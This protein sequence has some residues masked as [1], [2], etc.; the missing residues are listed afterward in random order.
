MAETTID[1]VQVRMEARS[2]PVTADL[3]MLVT[4]AA[5]RF[6]SQRR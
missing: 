2:S 3:G 6:G 4:R 1:P 5:R